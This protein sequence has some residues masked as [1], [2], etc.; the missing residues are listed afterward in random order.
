MRGIAGLYEDVLT[1]KKE[2]APWSYLANLLTPTGDMMQQ[3]V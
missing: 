1:Y 2:P 3:Q